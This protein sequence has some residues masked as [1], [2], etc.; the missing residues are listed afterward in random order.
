MDQKQLTTIF[1]ARPQNFAWFL[2]AGTSRSA[3]LPTAT[4]IIWD[5]KRRFYCQEENQDISRQDIQ[6]TAVKARIQAFMDSR[7]FPAAWSEEEYATYFEKIFGSDLER[8]RRYLRRILSEEKVTL[9]VGNRVLGA[10]MASGMCRVVFTTNF[11]TVVEKSV[12]EVANASL[13]AFHLEGSHAAIEAVNN[14]E[15]PFYCKLH[16]DFRYERLKNLPKDL[17]NQNVEL[18]RAFLNVCTRSGLVVAG[19]SGRDAS[20]MDLLHSILAASNPFPNGLYWTEIKNAP[21]N[22]AVQK[23]LE[24]AKAKGVDAHHVP[25]ETFDALMLRLWRHI[26]DKPQQLDAKVRKANI[27]PAHIPIPPTGSARPFLRLNALPI[28][29]SPTQC[30][31]VSF[32]SAKEWEN[33]RQAR[34]DSDNR[35]IL[36]KAEQIWCWGPTRLIQEAFKEQPTDV[37]I[38][39]VPDDLTSPQNLYLKRFVEDALCAALVRGKPLLTRTTRTSAFVLVDPHSDSAEGQDQLVRLVGKTS[40]TIAGLFTEVDEEYPAPE[41]IGWA[42]AIR[43]SIDTKQGR[44]WLLLEPDIWIWPVRA[45]RLAADFMGRRRG[46]RFNKKHNA[47]VTAW[48]RL[49]LGKADPDS[50]ITL[51]AFDQGSEAENPTF[52]IGNRTGFARGLRT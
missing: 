6:N 30:H 50:V 47:I 16:G 28:V 41:K 23:L 9:T 44:K 4:D 42:E 26:E 29:S 36:T 48:V 43:V 25:I 45:R 35:L 18:S 27:I 40:G 10:L 22:P 13:S 51:S 21:L 17:K 34:R 52:R 12:A 38:G 20:I 15:Y 24:S 3:G 5:L 2:G 14:E 7:G 11:D 19:Y 32:R 31:L 46:D 37:V 49:M 33:I 39:A 8:Q 1:C